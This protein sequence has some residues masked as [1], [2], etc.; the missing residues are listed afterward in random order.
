MI[1]LL[2]SDDSL[3]HRMVSETFLQEEEVWS[4]AFA[5][6]TGHPSIH[7]A[8]W[9]GADEFALVPKPAE[10]KSLKLAALAFGAINKRKSELGASIG[11]VLTEVSIGANEETLSA[12]AP[13][14]DDV[15]SAARAEKWGTVIMAEVDLNRR[16]YWN[17]LGDF[18][19]DLL[20]HRPVGVAE[21]AISRP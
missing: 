14:I 3:F 12:L 19:G 9:P 5:E 13:V 1:Y 21:P 17:S 16:L 2:V 4:W 18:K 20:R 8:P 7:R 11:R 15:M 6:E 10:P